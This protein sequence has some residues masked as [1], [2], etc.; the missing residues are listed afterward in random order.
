[1]KRILIAGA[2]ILALGTGHA[3]AQNCTTGTLLTLAQISQLLNNR[4]ACVPTQWN[5]LHSG[6]LVLD[7]KLGPASPI[8]P[9]D[10]ASHPTGSYAITGVSGPQSTGTI[11]YN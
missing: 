11:T 6:G 7:Y 1:M 9:S 4:Y 2:A 8:D 3:M 10:T 5:E